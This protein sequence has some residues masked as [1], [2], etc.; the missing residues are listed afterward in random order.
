MNSS[1]WWRLLLV[2][3]VLIGIAV[4]GIHRRGYL[5]PG[6]VSVA[7]DPK[8]SPAVR[9]IPGFDKEPPRPLAALSDGRGTTLAFVEN[10]LIYTGDD[11]AALEALAGRVRGKVVRIVPGDAA[12]RAPSQHLVRIAATGGDSRQLVSD[13]KALNPGRSG[14]LILSSDAGLA[15][16]AI[17]SHEAAAGQPVAI[18]FILS[19]TGYTDRNLQEGMSP[20]GTSPKIGEAFDRNPN[21]WSYFVRGPGTQNI[22]VGDAWRAL[23]QVQRLKK[24]VKIA[25]VDGGFLSNDD[26]PDDFTINTNSA[27]AQDPN[28]KN[29]QECSAGLVCDWHGTNVVGTAMGTPNNSY[30]AAGPAGPVVSGAVAIRLSG[31]VFNYL[32]S[33]IVARATNA[34]IVNMSFGAGVPFLLSWAVLPVEGLTNLMHDTGQLVVAAAGNDGLDV[35]SED[36]AWPLDWPCWERVWY[37]PCENGGVMCIGALTLN[38]SQKWS[39]SNYGGGGNVELFGPGSVWVGPDLQYQDVHGFFATSAASPFVAGVAALVVAANP[40]LTNS[41]VERILIET[42]N[43]SS[44]GNVRRY[45]NAYA[46]VLRALGG[47]PPDITIAVDAVPQFGGCETLY[48]FSATTS[49]PD[50]GPPVV[51]WASNLQNPLGSGTSFSRTLPPGIHR[52][53]ATATDGIGLSTRSNE[54]VITAGAAAPGKRPTIEIISLVNHQK[55][56]ANQDIT[57]EAGGLDPDKALGGLVSSN[58]LWSDLNAGPLGSGQPL[59]RRLPV[60]SHFVIVNY[61]G[62]CGGTADDQRLIEVTPAVADAP[63]NMHITTPSKADFVVRVDPASGE[64]CFKVGGF[65]F[66]EEDQDFATIDFWETNRNDLQLKLL[67][68]DQSATVCLK[69]VPGAASTTHLVTLRGRD[70]KGNL[71]ISPP[72]KVTVLPALH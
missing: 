12:L 4:W 23:D 47:T 63:P 49:D 30:G 9:T 22:G 5:L 66:D 1:K 27:W 48:S 21:K 18:N 29:E 24:T 71:G 25:V 6:R 20:V 10:E 64:A 11:T 15:L 31:D 65:G 19:S 35:D 56:A 42:A 57:F 61:T 38:S 67:S 51:K 3:L 45:V 8:I 54:V 69:L 14:N 72:L 70:K 34:R 37:V 46:A 52:I 62:I 68:F 26:N 58:V 36:C 41:Q 2:I 39:K 44:D 17:A 32:G 33:F 13:L 50:H 60:G 53:S 7:V 55:F 28:Q 16:V 40:T 59:I 43:P